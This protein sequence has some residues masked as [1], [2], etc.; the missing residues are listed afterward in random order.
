MPWA[1]AESCEESWDDETAARA[2]EEMRLT[3]AARCRADGLSAGS[4]PDG[5]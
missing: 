3:S 2:A 1:G 5:A 4:C